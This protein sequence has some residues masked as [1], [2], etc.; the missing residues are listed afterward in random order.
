[1]AERYL[2]MDIATDVLNYGVLTDTN[3]HMHGCGITDKH[4]SVWLPIMYELD[5]NW[6]NMYGHNDD[7]KKELII[8]IANKVPAKNDFLRNWNLGML[9]NDTSHVIVRTNRD[10][11]KTYEYEDIGEYCTILVNKDAYT[12]IHAKCGSAFAGGNVFV[13]RD[14][15]I[16]WTSGF[17]PSE[18]EAIKRFDELVGPTIK[19]L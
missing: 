19:A 3:A 1:M 15:K 8:Q 17:A 2:N 11:R 4:H 12:S 6:Y 13:S 18:K 14:K 9:Q 7:R 16:I 10:A 5:N